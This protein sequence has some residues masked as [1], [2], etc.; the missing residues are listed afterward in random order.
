MGTVRNDARTQITALRDGD[1]YL[2]DTAVQTALDWALWLLEG[3]VFAR[4]DHLYEGISAIDELAATIEE[5]AAAKSQLDAA[6]EALDGQ[7]RTLKKIERK[8]AKSA[9]DLATARK[10]LRA[11]RRVRRRLEQSRATR[12]AKATGK[13]DDAEKKPPRARRPAAQLRAESPPPPLR[14]VRIGDG[15]RARKLQE[16]DR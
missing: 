1:D 3:P 2:H 16:A 6:R 12:K 7:R 11:E 5:L 13:T 4:S 14:L 9:A 8:H 15:D 10:E